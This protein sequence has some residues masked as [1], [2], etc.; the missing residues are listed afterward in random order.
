VKI[1]RRLGPSIVAASFLIMMM[2]SWRGWPDPLIDFGQQLYVSWRLAEGEVLYRDV[3][4]LYGPLSPYLNALFFKLFG[5]GLMTLAICNLVI[6]G[7]IFL[8]VWKI[9]SAIG[10]RLSATVTGVVFAT[11]FAFGQLVEF[12]NYNFVCP[13]V[14][15][16]THGVALSL[17]AIYGLTLYHRYPRLPVVAGM[18]LTIGL[19]FLTKA[20]VFLAGGSAVLCG[21]LLT[22]L[23][24]R[25]EALKHLALF[26][27]CALVPPALSFLL[28]SSGTIGTW[29]PILE[30]EVT[31]LPFYRWSLGLRDPASSL[32]LLRKSLS[33]YGLLLAPAALLGLV[34][35]KEGR[36]RLWVSLA[37]FAAVGGFLAWWRVWW[38]ATTSFLPVAMLAVV[39]TSAVGLIRHHR[40]DGETSRRIITLTMALFALLLLGKILFF[41]RTYHYGFALAMPAVLLGIAILLGRLPAAIE[42]AGGYGGPL[43]AATLAV[44]VAFALGH[45]ITT[46]Q[47][48]EMKDTVVSSGRDGFRA[49][50]RGGHVNDMLG[51]IEGRTGPESTLTALPSG[52]MLGY[53]SR[54]ANPTPFIY[55]MP[56]DLMIYNEERMVE[57]FR[58]NPPD[59]VALVHK[60]SSEFGAGY[61]GTHYGRALYSWI[62][63]NYSVVDRVGAEPL[64]DERFGMALMRRREVSAPAPVSEIPPD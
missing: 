61:F 34:M 55:Y 17:L 31:G 62:E 2:W 49:D 27:A 13:Y 57:R 38:P 22:I 15:N 23:C 18:G 43:R 37:I 36:Y 45:I 25:R 53:L 11:S 5:L 47:Y 59:F 12:G 35:R 52:A 64:R 41:S 9:V 50:Q 1:A 8:L 30:G 3:A 20:E 4:Y 39:V 46:H 14:H 10:G 24:R 63:E 7:G 28:L 19:L 60:D 40:F 21:L 54:R 51:I 42:R 58:A 56:S 26:I 48:F 32:M 29:R 16:L 33:W 6:L 44:C